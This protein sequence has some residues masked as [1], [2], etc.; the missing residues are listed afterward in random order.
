MLVLRCTQKLLSHLKQPTAPSA[1]ESTT[2]LGDWYA[3][4]LRLGPRPFIL[5]VSE[6]SRLPIVL[7]LRDGKRLVTLIQDVVCEA[8][9]RAGVLEADIAAERAEMAEVTLGK[10]T[11]RRVLGTLNDF[12]RMAKGGVWYGR[13]PESPEELA[14][15]LAQSP[16]LTLG[17]ASPLALTLGSFGNGRKFKPSAATVH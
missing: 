14:A 8:L 7:P 6:R 2:R 13:E 1:T 10:T 15:F 12:S 11:D 16:I 4:I 9:A 3:N 17:G 5:L